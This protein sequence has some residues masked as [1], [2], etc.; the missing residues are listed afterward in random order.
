M[1]KEKIVVVAGV[2]LKEGKFFLVRR[3]L[4]K[5]DGGLWE[6]PGGKVEAG[7][8]LFDSLK[9]ELKEELGLEVI[10]GEVLATERESRGGLMV[11]I[12]FL[13]VKSFRGET[14]L[15]EAM[16]GGFFEPKEAL[17]LSLCLPDRRFIEKLLSL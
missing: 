13:L 15:K 1:P 12:H 5:R 9:R 8:D 4:H 17:K 10:E 16:E 7:E 2:I 3:P 6:F 11:E 14:I